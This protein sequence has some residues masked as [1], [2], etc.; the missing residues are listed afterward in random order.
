M[1]T[2]KPKPLDLSDLKILDLLTG[3]VDY[4]YLDEEWEEFDDTPIISKQT[5]QAQ[6]YQNFRP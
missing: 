2:K 1:N 6:S 3:M 5:V 4:Q